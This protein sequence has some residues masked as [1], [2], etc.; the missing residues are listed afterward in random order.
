MNVP[1][2]LEAIDRE[3]LTRLVRRVIQSAKVEVLDWQFRPLG[4]GFGNPVSLGLYRFSGKG[5]D[6]GETVLWSLVLKVIQ[7]PANVGASDMGEGRDQTH[8]N[9]W[10]REMHVYRCGLSIAMV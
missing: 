2:Q 7:S 9:Y 1:V 6:R 10:K 3:T 5:K 4:G 8:W